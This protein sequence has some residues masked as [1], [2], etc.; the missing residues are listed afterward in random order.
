MLVRNYKNVLSL[1]H[2]NCISSDQMCVRYIF[3]AIYKLTFSTESAQDRGTVYYYRNLLNARDVKGKVKNAYRPHKMLYYT[4]LDAMCL[5]LFL[6]E[7]NFDVDSDIPLPSHFKDLTND[8]KIQWLNEICSKILKKYFFDESS[9]VCEELREITGNPDHPENYWVQN[10]EDGRIQCHFCP[11]TYAYVG[12]LKAHE[13]KMH[14][15]TIGKQSKVS[16]QKDT[17]A[18][19]LQDYSLMLFKLVMLHKNLDSAVDMG[20]GE[21]SVRSTKYEL[22]IYNK[23]NK[24]K[25]SIGSIHL[26]AM[27]SGLLPATQEERLK[28][29][30]FINL[31]GGR[32]HNI[33]LDEFVEM[34]NRDSK[35]A[36]S[37][38]QTE[39]SIVQHSKEYPHIVNIA[40]HY[41]VIS[42]IKGKKGFHHLPSYKQDVRKVL[43][44][45][46]EINILEHTPK[47]LLKCKGLT[48]ERN[49]FNNAYQGLSAMI[50]RHR[51]SFPF[52]RLRNPHI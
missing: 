10:F 4:I 30:R 43:K 24:T 50:H 26:T 27:T 25:Y 5:L 38:H 51:P 21:R 40:K 28:A 37:G 49:P 45:L 17:K 32:N 19:Q 34:L 41:D 15:I 35:V 31:Q 12:S 23:T 29:N 44:D 16:K 42:D 46:Q 20:D 33:A 22:P 11:K 9:D 48:T 52:R 39:D 6:E 3:Q 13:S 36:C 7:L 14:N 18:D 47:R 2:L 8:E 1:S